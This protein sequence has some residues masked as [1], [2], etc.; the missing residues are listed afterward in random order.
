MRVRLVWVQV[1][2]LEATAPKLLLR[3]AVGVVV[4]LLM[5]VVVVLEHP[6]LVFV[7][8]TEYSPSALTIAV[9][10]D[11][12][13]L[14]MPGPAKANELPPVAVSVRLVR[15]QVRVPPKLAESVGVTTVLLLMVALVWAVQLLVP[16]AVTE[17][18]PDTLTTKVG[19]V[20]LSDQM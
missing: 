12:F 15:A 20:V 2:V 13:W 19:P 18:V 1:R 16:V 10:D 11:V 17:Y 9:P 7:T 3:L 8:V 4:L 5:L 14:T 6:V